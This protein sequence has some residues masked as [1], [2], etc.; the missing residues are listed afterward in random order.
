MREEQRNR[1]FIHFWGP[2]E[3]QYQSWGIPGQPEHLAE[4]NKSV[5][6]LPSGKIHS[7]LKVTSEVVHFEELPLEHRLVC[8]RSLVTLAWFPQREARPQGPVPVHTHLAHLGVALL[9]EQQQGDQG[10]D[11]LLLHSWGVG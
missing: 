9:H 8:N 5:V 2:T 10:A 11:E 7:Y 6:K 1:V 3:R 4:K